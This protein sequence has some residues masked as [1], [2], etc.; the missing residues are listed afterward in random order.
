MAL[1]GRE[2]GNRAVW[3]FCGVVSSVISLIMP[4]ERS[5]G[6]LKEGRNP[7]GGRSHPSPVTFEQYGSETTSVVQAQLLQPQQ[8]LH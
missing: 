5:M 3:G 4:F 2:E 8:Q 1:C 7:W 6:T